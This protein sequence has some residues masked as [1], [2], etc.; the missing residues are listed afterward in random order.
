MFGQG[1]MRS[2]EA[3]SQMEPLPFSWTHRCCRTEEGNNYD[4]VLRFIPFIAA[5]KHFLESLKK[6][7]SNFKA[8]IFGVFFGLKII[9]AKNIMRVF[10]SLRQTWL[11]FC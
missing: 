4:K 3:W 6:N 1:D 9:M 2:M 10:K 7:C 8:K 5:N 11:V